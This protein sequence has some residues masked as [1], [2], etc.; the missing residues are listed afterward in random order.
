[1]RILQSNHPDHCR[2]TFSLTRDAYLLLCQQLV[3]RYGFRTSRR[4]AVGILESFGM[5]LCLLRGMDLKQI[6]ELFDRGT[7]TVSRQIRKVLRSLERMV[8]DQIHPWTDQGEVHPYL[9]SREMY[10]P[11]K[12]C[13]GA[14]DGTHVFCKPPKGKARNFWGRKG[15][16]TMNI[17]AVVDFNL[18]FTFAAAGYEGSMHD[19]KIFKDVVYGPRKDKFPHPEPGKYYLV[20]AGYPNRPGYLAPYKGYRYHLEDFKRGRR[21][22]PRNDEEFFNRVHS[23]LRSCIERT[24]GVWKER[25][26]LMK[27][28]P[29]YNLEGYTRIV[30]TSMAI[31]NFIRRNC[32]TDKY[33][34]KADMETEDYEFVDLPDVANHFADADDQYGQ[35]QDEDHDPTMGHY[36]DLLTEKLSRYRA[37]NR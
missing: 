28:I 8:V 9:T 22:E 32:P 24:F 2:R 16:Y 23:S 31:H 14:I 7:S 12:D 11:F 36:R 1:M 13:I 4:S 6:D 5:Y 19:Y 3:E 27:M 25:W 20:D 26:N 18:C 30:L 37:R 10:G 33:F 34:E 35:E 29:S 21:R 15:G 17:M